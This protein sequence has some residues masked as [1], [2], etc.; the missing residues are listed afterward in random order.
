MRKY[1]VMILCGLFIALQIVL[2]RLFAIDV[3]FMR[4][5]LLFVPVAL[6]GAIFGPL[7][8]GLLCAA[9]DII[10]FLLVPSQGPFFPGFTLSA[11]L[12]GFAYGF[13]LKYQPSETRKII[14]P[15]SRADESSNSLM[16][17]KRSL[18]I[19]TLFVKTFSADNNKLSEMRSLLIRT[20]L[21]AFCVTIL[22]DAFLNTCWVAILYE[23]AYTFYF[24]TRFIKSLAML[25]VHVA[26]FGAIWRSLGKYIESVVLPKITNKAN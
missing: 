8:N 22:I 24:G 23:K 7:W 16:L 25:P 18:F 10:G 20:F 5:S 11:F 14:Y 26:V 6:G 21:A 3:V 2:G 9:A 12:S 19:K 17:A 13:F 4:V 15:L 1:Y